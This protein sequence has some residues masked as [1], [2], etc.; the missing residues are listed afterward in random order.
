MAKQRSKEMTCE[1]TKC[2]ISSII[3]IIIIIISTIT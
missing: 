1:V 3:I 2:N